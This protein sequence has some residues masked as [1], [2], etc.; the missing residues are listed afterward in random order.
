MALS[1]AEMLSQRL[2]ASAI[3]LDYSDSIAQLCSKADIDQDERR[4]HP[5][6]IFRSST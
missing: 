2:D 1:L 6:I 5:G 3:R 4:S